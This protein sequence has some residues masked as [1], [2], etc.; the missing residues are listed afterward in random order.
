MH[1]DKPYMLDF[2]SNKKTG[3]LGRLRASDD[4]YRTIGRPFDKLTPS[5]NGD[6]C[7]GESRNLRHGR[8]TRAKN[9][10]DVLLK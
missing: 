9:N 5:R 8:S 1:T 3:C 6:L 7:A 4:R 2:L 10:P